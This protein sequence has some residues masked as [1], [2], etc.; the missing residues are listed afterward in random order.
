[1]VPQVGVPDLSGLYNQL[2]NAVKNQPLPANTSGLNQQAINM[3]NANLAA[4]QAGYGQQL[5]Q[6]QEMAAMYQQL[7]RQQQMPIANFGDLERQLR[8][9]AYRRQPDRAVLMYGYQ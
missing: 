5:K 3:Y 9:E 7:A 6:Q 2:V 8:E 4:M 1:M